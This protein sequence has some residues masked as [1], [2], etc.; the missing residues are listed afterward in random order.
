M[1]GLVIGLMLFAIVFG[2]VALFG[3]KSEKS[4]F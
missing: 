1:A 3:V 2:V 4:I